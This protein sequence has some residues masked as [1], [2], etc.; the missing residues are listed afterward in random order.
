MTLN[1]TESYIKLR[2]QIPDIDSL[3]PQYQ[4]ASYLSISPVQLSRIRKKLNFI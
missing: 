3:I 1:A 2:K 4:I